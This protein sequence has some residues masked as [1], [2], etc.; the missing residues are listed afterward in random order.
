MNAKTKSGKLTGLS[1]KSSDLILVVICAF[2]LFIVAYPL[3]YC[4]CIKSV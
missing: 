3:Y 4:F 1:E 2:I